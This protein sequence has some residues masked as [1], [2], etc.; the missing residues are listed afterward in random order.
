MSTDEIYKTISVNLLINEDAKNTF[1]EV[2]TPRELI[3]ELLDNMPSSVYEDN[4]LRWF[5]SSCGIGNFFMIIFI[6][7]MHGLKKSIKN[8][9]SRKKHIIE[10]MLFMTE[11]NPKNVAVCRSIFG[12]TAN[13]LQLDFLTNKWKDTFGDTF[14]IIVGN[15]PFQ[16]EQEGKRKGGYNGKILW[17]LFVKRSLD[18]LNPAGYLAF[19]TPPKWRRPNVDLFE[20]MAKDRHLVYLH[21]YTES[22]AKRIFH[23]SQ[24]FDLYVIK[25]T[26]ATTTGTLLVDENN[27][28]QT[29]NV[30]KWPFL[31]NTEFKMI[32]KMMVKPSEIGLNVLYNTL[33]HTQKTDVVQK[34]KSRVYKYPVVHTLSSKGVG[35]LYANNNNG[36]FG[37]PKVILNFGRHQYPINDF[38]GEY[39]MSQI[40]FGIV[41]SSEQEGDMIIAAINS[42]NFKK[43]LKATK[44]GVF[45]TDWRMFTYFKQNFHNL[46]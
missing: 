41:I 42:P 46:L 25:N 26:H 40:S 14:D 13:I 34:T 32:S 6:R 17:D 23:V 11:L 3:E 30:K 35:L 4:T 24:R 20:I 36:H 39:G 22:D 21:I 38:K 19:I 8:A 2:F 31:P 9:T 18:I 7:L 43:I 15:P 5:D 27:I 37:V 33:F 29:I 44:W 28:S 45:Q 10:K 16:K 12:P 1:G